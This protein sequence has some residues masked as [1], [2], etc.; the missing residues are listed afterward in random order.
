MEDKRL[1]Y[2]ENAQYGILIL[3][4]NVSNM[5]DITAMNYNIM[6]MSGYSMQEL[7]NKN[8]SIL[9]P[10]VIQNYHDKFMKRYFDKNKG[11]V[12]NKERPINLLKKDNFILPCSL[13]IKP[14]PLLV[15]GIELI[16]LVA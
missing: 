11:S 7:K 10:R 9:C 12:M 15:R 3:S 4:G 8:V 16:G 14:V 5:G 6:K 1:K 2:N 13:L